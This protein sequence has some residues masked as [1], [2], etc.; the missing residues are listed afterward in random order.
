VRD[1]AL[2][3]QRFLKFFLTDRLGVKKLQQRILVV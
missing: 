3:A 1:C 2:L